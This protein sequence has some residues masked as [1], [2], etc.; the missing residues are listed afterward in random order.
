MKRLSVG[1]VSRK[2]AAV[3]KS[4]QESAL[5]RPE[6]GGIRLTT[7]V[8]DRKSANV[9]GN[10]HSSTGVGAACMECRGIIRDGHTY[11]N[12]KGCGDA[13]RVFTGKFFFFKGKGCGD[14]CPKR[15]TNV[16]PHL[17]PRFSTLRKAKSEE[18]YGKTQNRTESAVSE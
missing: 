17:L 14:F 12:I 15:G 9:G 13:T 18:I 10:R 7:T 8:V 11:W 5:V 6:V 4:S 3:G 1:K 2:A 16:P